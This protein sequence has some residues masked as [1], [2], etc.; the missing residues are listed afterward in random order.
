M[1][2][3]QGM[4]EE[5]HQPIVVPILQLRDESFHIGLNTSRRMSSEAVNQVWGKNTKPEINHREM[6][7]IFFEFAPHLLGELVGLAQGLEVSY[8]Q[9]AAMFSGYDVPIKKA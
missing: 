1:I 5:N 6:K 4:E 8:E 2:Q 3:S 7:S 9:A